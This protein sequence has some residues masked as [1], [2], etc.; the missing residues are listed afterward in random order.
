[1]SSVSVKEGEIKSFA[2]RFYQN[3]KQKTDTEIKEMVINAYG[4]VLL[5]EESLAILEKNKTTLGKTRLIDAIYV[6]YMIAKAKLEQSGMV[7]A[8]ADD[9]ARHKA[10]LM[11]AGASEDIQAA[12]Y[13]LDGFAERELIARNYL[14]LSSN[15]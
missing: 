2:K 9:V 5:T 6:E 12:G 4:N 8:T 7:K 15:R 10:Q 13:T 14:L 1:M 3:A 11:E